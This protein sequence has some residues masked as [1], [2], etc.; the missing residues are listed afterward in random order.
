M[1][2]V[3]VWRAVIGWHGLYEVSHHGRV[4]RVAPGKS[5]R[6]GRLLTPTPNTGGYLHVKLCKP[7]RQHTRTVHTLVAEA[8]LGVRDGLEP[9]HINNDRT[10]NHIRNLRLVTHQKN[11]WNRTTQPHSSRFKGVCWDRRSCRWHVQ[12]KSNQQ[13]RSLGYFADEITA[14][15]AYD[16]A[17]REAFGA[18]ARTNF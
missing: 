17:A 1:F 8:F 12:I 13:A 10:D 15:H 3:E 11:G 2:E 5:T 6:A 9:D 16:R 14:A 18:H 4:R 7:E